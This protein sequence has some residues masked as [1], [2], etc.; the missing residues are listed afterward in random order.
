M[1]EA[2]TVCSCVCQKFFNVLKNEKKRTKNEKK[3]TVKHEEVGNI[4]KFVFVIF[5]L[6]LKQSEEERKLMAANY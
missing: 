6:F 3:S 1:I 4:E 5:G 2:Y